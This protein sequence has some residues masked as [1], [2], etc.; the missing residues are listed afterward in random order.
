MN[1]KYFN[2]TNLAKI[3]SITEKVSENLG[4]AGMLIGGISAICTLASKAKSKT[5]SS[6]TKK[7]KKGEKKK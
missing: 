3:G 5:E 1:E 7:S 2:S 4:L 6:N